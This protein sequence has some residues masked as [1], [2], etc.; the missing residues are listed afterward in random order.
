MLSHVLPRPRGLP[1]SRATSFHG[2]RP[3]LGH[4][5]RPSMASG[6]TW[7]S[8]CVQAG[9]IQCIYSVVLHHSVL[10]NVS[11]NSVHPI[12]LA[13]PISGSQTHPYSEIGISRD[14]LQ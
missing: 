6:L 2:L 7:C 5:P 8:G 12:I 4:R 13:T 11:I 9:T 10:I 3:Y 1:L 14:N